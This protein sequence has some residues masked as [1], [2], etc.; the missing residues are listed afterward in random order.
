MY[1]P[2]LTDIELFVNVVEAASLTRGAEKSFMS[3]PAASIRMKTLE[4][5]LGAKL[6]SRTSQGIT[7]TPAGQTFLEH[8]VVVLNQMKCMEGDLSKFASGVKG[9]VRFFANT[10]CVNEFLPPLLTE[11]LGTHPDISVNLEEHLS[12]KIAH[13]LSDGIAD[14]GVVVGSELT[15]GLEARPFR[16]YRMVVVTSLN[17]PLGGRESITLEEALAFEYIGLL[18]GSSNHTCIRQAAYSINKPLKCRIQVCNFEVLCSMV[19]ADVGIGILSDATAQRYA[20]R[21]PISVIPITDS[22]ALHES[23]ICVRGL[24][25]LP[26]FTRD[27]FDI[28]VDAP[29]LMSVA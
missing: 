6:L 20:K 29:A 16:Q 10:T 3:L 23:F 7:V 14:I 13:A 19:L 21:M 2:T 28:L 25:E 15:T 9:H 17:H 8:A 1:I 12:P 26:P 4:E 27:L 18:Q 5:R 22:W 24:E 11:F